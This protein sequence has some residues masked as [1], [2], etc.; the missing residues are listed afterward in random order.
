MHMTNLI[1]SDVVPTGVPWQ[2]GKGQRPGRSI[3]YIVALI[4]T[5]WR[6]KPLYWLPY[7]VLCC[8]FYPSLPTQFCSLFRSFWSPA[9]SGIQA[10]NIKIKFKV[11]SIRQIYIFRLSDSLTVW[12][13][14]YWNVRLSH[15]QHIQLSYCQPVRLSY[16]LTVRLPDLFTVRQWDC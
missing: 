14:D 10:E 7:T 6:Y 15:C 4:N 11:Q 3:R 9:C 12:L 5:T 13:S 1:A 16:F 8:L 2:D